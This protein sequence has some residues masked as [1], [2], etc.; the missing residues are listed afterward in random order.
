MGA[1]GEGAAR[2][3][4]C[5]ASGYAIKI[6]DLKQRALLELLVLWVGRRR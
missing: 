4:S 3:E 5:C 6:G 2:P 1:P